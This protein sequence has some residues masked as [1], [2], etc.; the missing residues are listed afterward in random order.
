MKSLTPSQ[1]LAFLEEY[2]QAS[3]LILDV[4][5]PG[6]IALASIRPPGAELLCIPMHEIPLRLQE[7]DQQRPVLCLCHHGVRSAQVVAFL[8]HM[9]WPNVYNVDGGIDAWSCSVDSSI[10]RY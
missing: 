8:M 6:E 4:R 5:E 7:I 2:P 3:P 1:A 9:G 10:P